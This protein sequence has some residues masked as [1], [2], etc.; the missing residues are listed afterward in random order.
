MLHCGLLRTALGLRSIQG[1]LLER[2]CV[3]HLFL[4]LHSFIFHWCWERYLGCAVIP[5]SLFI[6]ECKRS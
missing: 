6:F 4:S 5:Y 3:S 1:D 2:V